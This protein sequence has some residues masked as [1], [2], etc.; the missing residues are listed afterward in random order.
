MKTKLFLLLFVI[1]STISCTTN[2]EET[3]QKEPLNYQVVEYSKMIQDTLYYTIDYQYP[4]FKS[5]NEELSGRLNKLNDRIKY[6]LDLTEYTYWGVDAKGAIEIIQES[7]ASGKYELMNRYEVLDTT[8]L[9]ISLKFE[10]Y[11]YAL[12]AHGFTAINTYNFDAAAGNKLLITDA[13]DLSTKDK[14]E[15]FNKLLV[16]GFV[17]PDHC[18]DK[19]PAIDVKFEKFAISPNYLIV[20]F[21]AYELGPYACGAAEIMIS[22]DELKKAGLWKL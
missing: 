19:E 18:F 4:F 5:E 8:N 16:S 20:Y 3:K 22:I 21:E 17:N 1:A 12:G 9:L 2:T 7:E 14:L 13:V 15:Q 10:T 11:S 6:F